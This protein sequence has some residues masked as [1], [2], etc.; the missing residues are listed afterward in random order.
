M[1]LVSFFSANVHNFPKTAPEEKFGFCYEIQI[2]GISEN[3][4]C[5]G[6]AL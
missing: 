3:I 4:A 5:F 1:P 2:S 6:N